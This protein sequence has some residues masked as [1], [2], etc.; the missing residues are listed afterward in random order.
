VRKFGRP[1]NVTLPQVTVKN[2]LPEASR[3]IRLC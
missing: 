2:D 3:D 1:R